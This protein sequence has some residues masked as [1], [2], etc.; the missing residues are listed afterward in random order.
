MS[1]PNGLHPSDAIRQ[2]NLSAL[3]SVDPALAAR[4]EAVDLPPQAIPATGRDGSPT[5]RIR[6]AEGER[7]FGHTSMPTISGPALLSRFDPGGGNVVLPGIGQGIEARLLTER[8]GPNRAVFVLESDLAALS[9]ALRVHDLSVP[10]AQGRLIPIV[11]DDLGQALTRFLAD[12][13]GYL[14]PERMMSLPWL[15]PSAVNAFTLLMQRVVSQATRQRSIAMAGLL[16]E[17]AGIC[18]EHRPLPE[19]PRTMLVCPHGQGEPLRLA[20]EVLA[21]LSELGW[22]SE[23]WLGDSPRTSH[24]LRLARRLVAFRPDL[25]ILLDGVRAGLSQAIPAALRLACWMSRGVRLTPKIIEGIGPADRMFCMSG[26]TMQ[27]L[28]AGGIPQARV[29]WLGPAVPAQALRDGAGAIGEDGGAGLHDVIAVNNALPLSPAANGLTLESHCACWSVAER[30]IRDLAERYTDDQV[31]RILQQAEEQTGARFGDPS[32]RRAFLDQ[33]N[34]V[35]GHALVCRAAFEAVLRSG[36]GLSVWGWG[37][38]QFPELKPACRGPLPQGNPLDLHSRARIVLHVDVTGQVTPELLS[39]AARGAVVVARAHPGDAGPT[40]LASYLKP[41]QD[42][43]VFRRHRDLVHEIKR[44]LADEPRRRGMA[45]RGRA[46]VAG[47]HAM[48]HRLIT[49]WKVAADAS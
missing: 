10:L 39:A 22:P 40:G 18:P 34:T 12:N 19:R 25:V 11:G 2:G 9:M 15:D 3:R 28:I 43:L 21:G 48:T 30:R 32:L 29:H 36:I 47:R 23:P 49:L 33:M 26:G 38:D 24:P 4:L 41:G 44:L 20:R 13:E 1:P 5:F 35:L 7:W 14:V 37:W 45:D 27:E 16:P 8:L 46:T 42:L 31:E 6:M 17:L